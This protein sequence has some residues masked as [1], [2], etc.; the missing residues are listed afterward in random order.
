MEPWIPIELTVRTPMFLAP[1]AD[2]PAELRMP[3][4]RGAARFWFRALAAP[5]FDPDD[6]AALA[7]AETELFGSAAGGPGAG[8]A[9]P[10]RVAFRIIKPPRPE[11]NPS[12]PWLR[13][14]A[15]GDRPDHGIGYLL[16]QGLYLPP[17]SRE[18]R[19]HPELHRRSHL[20]PD[21]SATF[22]VRMTAG[23]DGDPPVGYLREAVGIALWAAAAFGGLGARTRRGFGGFHLT[24]L[25]QLA[26]V[27]G[28]PGDQLTRDHPA[29][30]RLHEIVAERH[31]RPTPPAAEPRPLGTGT[32]PW[33]AA[34][35][36]ARWHLQTS[37]QV[38]SWP[39]LLHQAGRALRAFR[40]PVD[41]T[42]PPHSMNVS[43]FK[44]WVT[45]E[46]IDAVV[47]TLRGRHPQRRETRV[48]SFGLP[49]VFGKDAVVN[50]R[51]DGDEL[52]RASP[53]W[54]RAHRENNGRF[55][56]LYHVFEA[57]IGPDEPGVG[58]DL[59]ARG[60]TEPMRLDETLAYRT[61][62]GFLAEAP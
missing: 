26:G 59:I 12:P 5:V 58:V 4:L 30:R 37:K 40:A 23:S 41:R 53:L 36:W 15:G 8:G 10:S 9:G 48:G 18:G 35:T 7:R 31:G 2:A 27:T 55:R 51:K 50:L 47:P 52:R 34:P 11:T 42:Q 6:H 1:T 49:V 3:A 60:R 38:G 54:I 33:P 43:S 24:G 61:I 22:A 56:L 20:P 45:H 28:D 13:L 29:I 25:D 44:R 14:P 46:Y 17:S 32:A 21:A 16:G 19:Q 62:A 57:R 39:Q